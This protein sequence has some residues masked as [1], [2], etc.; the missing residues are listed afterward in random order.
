MATW[1]SVTNPKPDPKDQFA[2]SS[3]R[4]AAHSNGGVA[5]RRIRLGRPLMQTPRVGIRQTLCVCGGRSSWLYPRPTNADAFAGELF[6]AGLVT[7]AERSDPIPSRTRPSNAQAPMVLCLKTWESRSSPG[8]QR[9][10]PLQGRSAA[11]IQRSHRETRTSLLTHHP[12]N[13]ERRDQ[14]ELIPDVPILNARCRGVEQPG[15][16]SGS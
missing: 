5:T 11:D 8:L 15:S 7:F 10:E 2:S 12:G 14:T 16:S 9:T 4:N 6:F 3:S 1:R 13:W